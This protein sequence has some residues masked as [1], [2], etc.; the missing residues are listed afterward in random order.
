MVGEN[1][2]AKHH[3]PLWQRLPDKT[4]K[5]HRSKRLIEN[6]T[7][8]TTNEFLAIHSF[9]ILLL[10][11]EIDFSILRTERIL[12]FKVDSFIVIWDWL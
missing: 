9:A 1:P 2:S 4:D 7:D 5:K 12:M 11:I 3:P 10:T 8:Y 6:F